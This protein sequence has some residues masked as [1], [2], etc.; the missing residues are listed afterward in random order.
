MLYSYSSYQIYYA[1]GTC[2]SPRFDLGLRL[3]TEHNRSRLPFD[4][5]PCIRAFCRF[6]LFPGVRVSCLEKSVMSKLFAH[7]SW[8]S[9][10]SAKNAIALWDII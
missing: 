4:F 2:T 8:I 9:L 3:G 5:E 7:R 6:A 1:A 10:I